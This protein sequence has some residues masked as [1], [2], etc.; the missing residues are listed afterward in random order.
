MSEHAWT[1][2][3]LA[4]LVAGGLAPDERERLEQHA[5]DCAD[6]GRAL[7]D[8]R[9]ADRQMMTLFA[10]V[11]P[12]PALEDRLIRTLREP[13]KAKRRGVPALWIKATLAIA[14]VAL[15]AVIGAGVTALIDN[16]WEPE[17]VR[18]QLER[19]SPQ[20]LA[21]FSHGATHHGA[22]WEKK[23]KGQ[24]DYSRLASTYFAKYGKAPS[25]KELAEEIYRRTNSSI[26][27][28]KDGPSVLIDSSQSIG[29]AEGKLGGA[30]DPK[31][32]EGVV[33]P[34]QQRAGPGV[35]GS[36]MIGGGIGGFGGGMMMGGGMMG[37]GGGMVG[38]G[39]G[40]VGGGVPP[41]P[42][43][44]GGRVNVRG[45]RDTNGSITG[46]AGVWSA[47]AFSGGYRAA[48]AAG[49]AGGPVD[50][51]FMPGLASSKPGTVPT[52][53]MLHKERDL[54]AKAVQ[55]LGGAAQARAGHHDGRK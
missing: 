4:A 35:S 53:P 50:D 36:G 32:Q 42:P 15:L 24:E 2:E 10:A 16:D 30:A 27:W 43:E 5:A 33:T 45:F 19:E 11:R 40:K 6:C 17:I 8:A 46:P 22:N 44:Q 12:S 7:A 29:K 54:A 28:Q 55:S 48:A 9:R 47:D 14:A 51:Y 18:M 23:E 13:R 39:G 20:G 34:E 1:L 52:Q 31:V 21:G 38:M 41:P 37:M 26:T 3:N 49:R 25:A